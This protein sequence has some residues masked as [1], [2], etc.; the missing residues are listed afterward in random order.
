MSARLRLI[1][2][3]RLTVGAFDG[4]GWGSPQAMTGLISK[5]T[6]GGFFSLFS[7]RCVP[8]GIFL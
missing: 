4:I 7:L 3:G 1:G 5:L 8:E 6:F 2:P